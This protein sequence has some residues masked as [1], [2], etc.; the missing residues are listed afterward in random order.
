MGRWVLAESR[1]RRGKD[2][3]EEQ[4]DVPGLE[5]YLTSWYPSV[6]PVIRLSRLDLVSRARADDSC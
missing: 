1:R 5:E 3:G 2:D 4:K 6:R